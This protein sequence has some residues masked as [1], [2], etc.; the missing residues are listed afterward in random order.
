M[1][2]LCRR[3]FAGYTGTLYALA[4]LSG[5]GSNTEPNGPANVTLDPPSLAFDAIGQTQPLSPTVTDQQGNAITDAAVSWTTS[6]PAVASVSSSGVVTAAGNG[7][8]EIPPR[9]VQLTPWRK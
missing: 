5:C 9:R 6:D 1:V 8:A 4:L 3:A 2:W 7:S